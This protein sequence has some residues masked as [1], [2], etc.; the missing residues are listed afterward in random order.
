[1]A[2]LPVVSRLDLPEDARRASSR[3]SQSFSRSFSSDTYDK[4]HSIMRS[5][6]KLG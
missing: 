3:V 1:M 4:R 2:P 5:R 6:R